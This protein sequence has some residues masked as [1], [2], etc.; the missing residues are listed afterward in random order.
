M[1]SMCQTDRIR[2]VFVTMLSALGL[3]WNPALGDDWPMWRYDAARSATSPAE[4][5]AE[6]QPQWVREYPPLEPAWEDRV[7]QDRMPF[8]RLYEPIAV[9]SSLLIGSSRS[10]RLTA[11]DTRSGVEKWRFYADGP[12]RLAPVAWKGKVYF[13]SDD[14]YLYC[15]NIADGSLAWKFRGGPERYKIL[16]NGRLVSTWPARGGPVIKEGK[17]YFSAGIWPFM[18]VSIYALDAETGEIV[19][20]NDGQSFRY[21]NQPH[22]APSFAGVAPQGSF[23]AIGDKLLVPGGRSV[24]ACFDRATGKLLYYHLAGPKKE[25]GSHV[26]A[27]GRFYFNHRGLGTNMYDLESGKRYAIRNVAGNGWDKNWAR[28]TYPVLDADR[29]YLSGNP[30]VAYDLGSL[31]EDF[32]MEKKWDRKARKKIDVRRTYWGMKRLWQLDVDATGGMIKAGNRLYVGGVGSVSAIESVEGDKPRIAW[33]RKIEGTAARLIAAD[34]RLFVVTLEGRIYAFGADK[35]PV[36]K[37]VK[38]VARND[39][40]PAE[41]VGRA[42]EILEATD[43]REGYCLVYGVRDG[44][45]VEALARNSQLNII[46]IC[47]DIDRVAELRRRF[48]DAGLYGRRVSVH[49]GDGLSFQAPPYLASLVV[50]EQ[51]PPADPADMEAIVSHVFRSVRPYGGVVYIPADR[52][53]RRADIGRTVQRAQ[54]PGAKLVQADRFL[55]LRR[56]GPLPGADDWTHQYGDIANSAKSDDTL[57]KAPLGLLWFGGNSHRDILPRHSHGPPEQIVGG[58]LFI[59]GVNSLSARD[60]YTGRELW[61]R[62]F[63]DLGTF[64]V[65]YD[66]SYKEDPLD[67]T[68]NQEHIPGAN[69]RGTNFVVAPDKIYLVIADHCMVLDPAT[70][71]TIDT[72]SLPAVAGSQ[73]KPS[74]GYIGVYEDLLI[75]GAGMIP[76]SKVHN[77]IRTLTENND[78]NHS[79]ALVVMNR[80]TG[81]VLWRKEARHAFRH[82]A[83]AVGADK[84]FCIDSQ[85]KVVISEMKRRGK[86]IPSDEVLFALDIRSGKTIWSRTADVFGTWLGYSRVHDLL[87]QSGRFSQDMVHGE[88]RDR[89]IVHRAATGQVVWDKPNKHYGPC[90]LHGETIYLSAMNMKRGG[91]AVSLLTGEP[92]TYE[93]PLTGERIR[94]LYDRGYGCNSVV[95]SEHLLMFRSGAAGFYDLDTLGGTGNLGGFKSGCTSNLIAANGVLNAPDYTR[96]CTC[97][98]QN[99]TSLA[100][101]HDPQVEVWTFNRLVWS[102]AAIRRVGV[103]LGA[104]GDRRADNGTL[105]LEYP[106][107]GGPSPAVPIAVEG[108]NIRWFHHHSS[109]MLAGQQKWVAASG[110]EGLTKL[111]VSLVGD[112]SAAAKHTYTVRLLFAEPYA[113]RKGQRVFDVAIGGR[114]LL[115]DFDIAAEADGAKKVIVK[116]FKGIAASEKME[117]SLTPKVGETLLCGVEIVA[118]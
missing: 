102:G 23:V 4:L 98:Y 114:T 74:W 101:I 6:L 26:S 67:T 3:L 111:T 61:K 55:L 37:P 113:K 97:A 8:D 109:R 45:L 27:T 1:H 118:R 99:Q 100:L 87:L 71:K 16:G 21:M 104:P 41:A 89:M 79:R 40:P 63:E 59:Q 33:T 51:F 82:N 77:I 47:P 17:V 62:T 76:I 53:E 60:V 69:A 66:A 75:A 115:K 22:N 39:S 107:V 11:L 5:P 103:N 13:V 96:T 9:G 78:F 95:A 48:D 46:A 68:Y 112:K 117:I 57:V 34:D 94:W 50:F 36:G 15:V 14:G 73:K 31:T 64:D 70:G 12:I 7:N 92:K 35:K 72:I 29:C 86:Q 52:Q 56:E 49:H 105:W 38:D 10:D 88:A 58:R 42:R 2:C 106:T 116:E 110:A 108:E 30:V 28:T 54:L 25:G 83:I 85:P 24:P 93:H 80:H 32:Y 18:G 19:W 65:Y 91:S 20:V 90:M 44:Y 84:L 81:K 43:V